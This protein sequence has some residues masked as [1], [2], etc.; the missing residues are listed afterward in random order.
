MLFI[1]NL[2]ITMLRALNDDGD[3]LNIIGM[4]IMF[5]AF[6]LS[7]MYE[8]KHG[9]NVGIVISII[10]TLLSLYILYLY[11]VK[12]YKNKNETGNKNKNC[13]NDQ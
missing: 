10:T 8:I 5:F 11:V 7:I 2:I 4:V 9:S 1:L 6:I 13:K 12:Y 3:I